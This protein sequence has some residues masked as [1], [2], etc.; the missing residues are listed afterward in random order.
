VAE[1]QRI[2]KPPQS[3]IIRGT[4]R[5]SIA[6]A[7]LGDTDTT[8][9]EAAGRGSVGLFK[10]ADGE[11]VLRRCRRGGFVGK[12]VN[13]GYLFKNRPLVEFR[14][15]EHLYD[16]GVSV[17][18]PLGVMWE[19]HG[20]IF[21]GAIATRRV[22]AVGLR[23][24]LAES[25]GEADLLLASIGRLISSMHDAGVYHADLHVENI[26]V[27]GENAFLI[28]FDNARCHQSLGGIRRARNLLRLR[29]SFQK[30]AMAESAFDR[31]LE[32]YGFI[33]FPAWLDAAYRFK[34]KA[35]DLMVAS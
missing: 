23:T 33:T 12:M 25:N 5:E 22:E 8:P 21:R 29:R 24:W 32:G 4:D 20:P 28:D 15:H 35:S 13:E 1:Y 3:T 7:L 11:G 26:L 19:Q 14:V 2:N 31:I 18:E 27:D 30:W 10:L 6:S 16:G 17:P 9:F 34:A